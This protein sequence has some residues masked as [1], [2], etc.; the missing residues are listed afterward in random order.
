MGKNLKLMA[1]AHTALRDGQIG[2]AQHLARVE[3]KV[4]GLD[5][6]LSRVETDVSAIKDHLG[7][8]EVRLGHVEVRVGKIE[9]HIGLNGTPPKKP[10]RRKPSKR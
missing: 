10:V 7:H 2:L 8:V 6:R 1:E 9:H 4:D 5:L 3:T